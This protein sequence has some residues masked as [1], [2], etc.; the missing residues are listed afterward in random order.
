VCWASFLRAALAVN[1]E[2]QQPVRS[3]REASSV[4]E[5]LGQVVELGDAPV[6]Q[7]CGS[8]M[9]RND[10]EEEEEPKREIDRR[11]AAG[12]A[13]SAALPRKLQVP[14]KVKVRRRK[15]PR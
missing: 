9:V 11:P 3:D 5:A 2:A 13:A 1:H 6:C 10:V 12:K 8:L 15:S 14:H 4:V 7:F